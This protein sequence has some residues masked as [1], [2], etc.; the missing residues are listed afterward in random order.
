MAD[1]DKATLADVQS[2]D[3]RNAFDEDG[4]GQTKTGATTTA[5]GT[6]TGGKEEAKNDV[7]LQPL[8][9]DGQTNN[10]KSYT[11]DVSFVTKVRLLLWKNFK[12][13]MLRRPISCCC[14]ACIPILIMMIMGLI[15]LIPGMILYIPPFI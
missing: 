7:E 1:T 4:G 14:K 9:N 5:G 15:T 8:N 13:Q 2:E 12:I 10:F 6:T 3:V 11:A